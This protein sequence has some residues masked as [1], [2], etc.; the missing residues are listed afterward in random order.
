[1]A[2]LPALITVEELRTIDT[3]E[4]CELHHGVVVPVT[5]PASKHGQMQRWLRRLIERLLSKDWVV[6]TELP[7]RPVPQFELRRGDVVVVSKARLNAVDPDDNL[8]GAPELVIE[9]KSPSNTRRQLRELA[10]LCLANGC[11]SFWIVDIDKQ[12]ITTIDRDGKSVLLGIG[13]EI[14]LSVL[15]GRLSVRE[16]FAPEW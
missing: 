13:D 7:Y 9:V 12:S 5:A 6:D 15:P 8:R 3:P 1:M 2:A 10:S 16:I 4:R 14:P 11:Q